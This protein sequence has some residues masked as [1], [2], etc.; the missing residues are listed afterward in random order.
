MNIDPKTT[1]TILAILAILA[2][3]V[4]VVGLYAMSRGYGDPAR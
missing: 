1:R 4:V 3:V 2:A